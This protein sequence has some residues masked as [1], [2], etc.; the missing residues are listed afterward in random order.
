MP[1]LTEK[2]ENKKAQIAKM[3]RNLNK[4]VVD[5]DFTAM[6]DRYFQT[7]D[8][9]ELN[10]Y[11]KEHN[12][13]C[14][15]EYYS[16]R[17][18]LEDAIETLKKYEKQLITENDKN[19][20]LNNLPEVVIE[21][22]NNLIKHWNEYDM[23]KKEEIKKE[24]HNLPDYFLNKEEYRKAEYEL[25]S[26]WGRGYY[27]F[28]Y[29]TEEQIKK[30]NEKDADNLILNMINRTIELT[31][32]ITDCKGLFLDKDNNGFTIINGLI[33]GKKGKAR[34]ESILAGGYNIQRLHIR[35]LVKEI[36]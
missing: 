34:I 24:Y 26:K 16:K 29:L 13:W 31:G 21:F 18:D 11:K 5:N 7:K 14:L 6:C 33:I 22:K 30:Q 23:W 15:P 32:I 1:T 12:M 36:K 19:A 10:N 17:H 28:M 4:Y 9:T 25:I 3:Q 20:T 8:F 27:D 35:V 2:I